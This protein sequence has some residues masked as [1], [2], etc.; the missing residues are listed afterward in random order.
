MA[1][2]DT[3]VTL[4]SG[5]LYLNNVDVGHLKG[6]VNFIVEGEFVDFKPANMTSATRRFVIREN[7]RLEAAL[8]EIKASN[9][10]LALGVD[11][12]MSEDSSWPNYDPSSYDAEAGASW[13]INYF[14]GDRTVNEPSLRFEHDRPDSGDKIIVVFYKAVSNRVLNIPFHE[15]DVN[16]SDIVFTAMGDSSRAEGDQLGFVAVEV[17]SS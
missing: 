16:L 3:L 13:D 12:A 2:D 7:C 14:G 11:T 9:M 10:R 5:D 8:A 17:A 15:E 6:D 4:G 1:K